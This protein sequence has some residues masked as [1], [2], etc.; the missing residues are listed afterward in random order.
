ML[1]QPGMS[2]TCIQEPVY[3]RALEHA[4]RLKGGAEV[5]AACLDVSTDDVRDWERGLAPVPAPVFL[6]I[7]DLIYDESA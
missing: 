4:L 3:L 5:L 2:G 7:V 1:Q 6:K